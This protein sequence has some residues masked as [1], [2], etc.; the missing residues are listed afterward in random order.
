MFRVLV[1]LSAVMLI[2]PPATAAP[3]PKEAE[4]VVY[5]PTTL[6]TTWAE[7]NE[8]VPSGFECITTKKVTAVEQK[9]GDKVA[10]ISTRRVT[11]LTLEMIRNGVSEFRTSTGT[12]ELEDQYRITA[13]AVFHIATRGKETGDKWQVFEKP[14]PHIKLPRPPGE[15]VV[16]EYPDTGRRVT[17]TYGKP[18]KVTVRAGTF[19]AIPVRVEIT[20]RGEPDPVS[21]IWYAAGIGPIKWQAG[22]RLMSEL[23]SYT[24]GKK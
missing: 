1:A 2:P 10:T 16:T 5:L 24:P 23:I 3:V 11:S 22:D 9:G 8:P 18:E 17:S 14:R 13:G 12:A 6:G 20:R 4:P 19:E 7:D 15:Q 21:T